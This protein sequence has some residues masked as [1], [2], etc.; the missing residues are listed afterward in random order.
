MGSGKWKP[1]TGNW[2]FFFFSV[3]GNW[4]PKR[5]KPA[6]AMTSLWRGRNWEEIDASLHKVVAASHVR[7]EL[8]K[9]PHFCGK[10]T[11]SIIDE[12]LQGAMWL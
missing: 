10:K 2:N 1:E 3:E 8:T 9:L 5:S 4:N 11:G 12:G 6:D 7:R